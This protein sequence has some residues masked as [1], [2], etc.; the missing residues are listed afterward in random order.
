[1]ERDRRHIHQSHQPQLTLA[2]CFQ[3]HIGIG[4]ARPVC[5][6]THGHAP[7]TTLQ[8][9]PTVLTARMPQVYVV[10]YFERGLAPMQ[11]AEHKVRILNALAVPMAV[12]GGGGGGIGC[13]AQWKGLLDRAAAP[14]H[15]KRRPLRR[16]IGPHVQALG[17]VAGL[18]CPRWWGVFVV[19]S[20]RFVTVH[21]NRCLR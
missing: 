5:D 8:S 20:S 19:E 9:L 11:E 3:C 18:S 15:G 21:G 4:Y 14:G 7:R 6:A 1:M 2:P 10:D 13:F 16:C 17:R 12:E